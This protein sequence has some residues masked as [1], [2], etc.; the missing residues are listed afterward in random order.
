MALGGAGQGFQIALRGK[1]IL[2]LIIL[3]VHSRSLI[4]SPLAEK[5]NSSLAVIKADLNLDNRPFWG[6]FYILYR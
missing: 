5:E 6:S 3:A 4:D 2:K 1:K